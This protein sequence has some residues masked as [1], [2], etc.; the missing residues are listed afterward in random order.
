MSIQ[1][2]R[3][4]DAI[5]TAATLGMTLN[6]YADPIE[7]ARVGLTVAEAR[8]VASEDASLI[9]LELTVD[10]ADEAQ[11]AAFDDAETFGREV[12]Q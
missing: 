8:A 3:G 5:D 2:L 6:K 9:W 12:A 4:H 1:I 10:D 7:D 11:A